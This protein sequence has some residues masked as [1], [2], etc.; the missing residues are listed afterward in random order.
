MRHKRIATIMVVG[1]FLAFVAAPA[2]A[3][4]NYDVYKDGVPDVNKYVVDNSCWLATASNVLGGAGWGDA[5]DIYDDLIDEFGTANGGH[6]HAAA[7]WWV[8]NIGLD[9]AD[10]G[11]GYNPTCSYVNFRLIQRTLTAG[12]YDFLLD[13]LNRCQYV[14]VTW[15]WGGDLG[16]CMT[17]V[18]GNYACRQSG[19]NT[20]NSV[21]HDSDDDIGTTT[22]T[23]M[24]K[25]NIGFTSSMSPDP[26]YTHPNMTWKINNENW[27]A[28]RAFL[29]CPGV[30]KPADAIG[31]FDVHYYIGVG[32]PS[33]ENPQSYTTKVEMLTTGANHKTYMGPNGEFDAEWDPTTTE[34]TLIVPNLVVDD[35][36]KIL[37][38]LVDFNNPED[39]DDTT[40]DDIQVFDDEGVEILLDSIE[41]S[42][43]NGQVLLTYVF[44]D[45]PAWET[46]V[47]PDN[48]YKTL[49]GNVFEWNIATECVPEPA[50]MSLLVLGA[51]ALVVRRKRK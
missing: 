39:P 15:F 18:G 29:A 9:E 34:P 11:Q 47:F 4:D 50:T 41:W 20:C 3:N 10:E 37:Y 28:D 21:W 49:A 16:H 24:V 5:Y 40:A 35:L 1:F 27:W 26:P 30:P 7:K 13:E 23:D 14:S 36:H 8:H 38:L 48:S 44:D 43:D 42:S 32:P 2:A 45:Q 51:I 6:A 17:L 33:A 12:D 22:V 31:N 19:F 25:A 46:I